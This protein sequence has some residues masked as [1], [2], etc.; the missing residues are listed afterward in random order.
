MS[1]AIETIAG[2]VQEGLSLWKTF[3]ATRQEA[4]NRK[5]DKRKEK[6]ISYAEAYMEV[7]S[8]L[9]IYIHEEL[10]VPEDKIKDFSKIKTKMYRIK[11]QFNKYD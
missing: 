1:K 10:G 9:F 2:A 4:Y 8:E 3:I 7:A 11:G 6:A 5:M